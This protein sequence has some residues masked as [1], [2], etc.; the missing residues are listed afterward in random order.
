M[1][2]GMDSGW[3]DRFLEAYFESYVSSDVP[4][5]RVFERHDCDFPGNP[6]TAEAA[7]DTTWAEV[8]RLRRERPDFGFYCG[9]SVY[10]REA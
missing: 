7:W 4:I 8:E 6:I 3:F 9:Q 2:I 5:W 1:S 10:A